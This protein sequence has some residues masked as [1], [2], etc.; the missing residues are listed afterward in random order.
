M[1]KQ[2][3][4]PEIPAMIE[5]VKVV[6]DK[7]M[8]SFNPFIA[9]SRGFYIEERAK[10]TIVA[11]GLEIIDTDK[12]D[13]SAG[14]IG[15][16]EKLDTSPFV[17]VYT[18]ELL[19]FFN[20]SKKAQISLMAVMVA[21]QEQAKNRAEIFLPYDQAVIYYKELELERIPVKGT[22]FRGIK[23]LV[24]K[25]FLAYHHIQSKYWINPNILF[26]GSRI[27]FV[28]QIEMDI[29]EDKKKIKKLPERGQINMLSS[30][31][32]PFPQEV[33]A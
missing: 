3:A 10:S 9:P 27:R 4:L 7:K 32:T 20:I 8:Y 29:K 19:R 26:N 25:E 33:D 13:I 30:E 5:P 15:K 18:N 31:T 11:G 1:G 2:K 12:N 28:Y 17:K 23:E 6:K 24:N 22:F 21:V 14:L 16:I